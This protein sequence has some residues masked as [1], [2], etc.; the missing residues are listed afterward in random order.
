MPDYG[1]VPTEDIE[2]IQSAVRIAQMVSRYVPPSAPPGWQG[3]AYEAVLDGILKDWVAN[4]TNELDEGDE[5]DLND[6]LRLAADT[7]LSQPETLRDVTF[8]TVLRNAMQ[9]WVDNWNAED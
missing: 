3:V 7:A 4:G 1:N 9:D 6:L 5:Q 2:A 8:R